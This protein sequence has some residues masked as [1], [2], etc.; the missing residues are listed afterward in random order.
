MS[1]V[2]LKHKKRGSTYEVLGVA[3]FQVSTANEAD[4]MGAYHRLHDGEPITVYRDEATG[5]LYARLPYEMI[6]GRFEVL[7][8]VAPSPG[9]ELRQKPN[10]VPMDPDLDET[11]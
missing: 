9:H 4:H 1:S 7:Q 2:R 6:D 11:G 3:H 5:K 10:L 8:P